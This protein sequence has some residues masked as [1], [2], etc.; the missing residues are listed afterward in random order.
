MVSKEIRSLTQM[1]AAPFDTH[2]I[3]T[4]AAMNQLTVSSNSS[5]NNPLTTTTGKGGRR[6][7]DG[8]GGHKE[9]KSGK[10]GGSKGG[11]GGSAGAGS[12]SGG[13]IILKK[14]SGVPNPKKM[15]EEMNMIRKV[16]VSHAVG[17]IPAGIDSVT[18]NAML[19]R[20]YNV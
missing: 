17:L 10:K 1:S 2:L 8:S 9:G 13:H 11:G 15:Y 3:P 7:K 6:I 4:M 20:F 18:F 19:L 12:G 16:K 5:F 14:A